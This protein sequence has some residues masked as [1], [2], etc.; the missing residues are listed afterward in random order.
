MA[1]WF[2]AIAVAAALLGG[3]SAETTNANMN[4]VAGCEAN[5]DCPSG[6]VCRANLCSNASDDASTLN[7]RFIP[8]GDSDYLPQFHEF[9]H[10]QPDEP[11][12]FL[13]HPA[14]SVRSGDDDTE[15]HP[16]GIRYDGSPLHGPQGTLIFRP[17]DAQSSL[18]IR[19]AHVDSGTFHARLNPGDYSLTFVPNDR[20][21]L[22][23]KSWAAQTFTNNT[24]LVRTL[25][26]PSEYLEVSG[27]LA[28]D[29]VL[30]GGQS[31][32]GRQVSNA[33]IYALSHNGEH[34]STIATTDE[35]GYFTLK[36]E[37]NTGRYDIF[38][39]PATSEAMVPSTELP[40]AF[41]AG[42]ADC[43]SD[44]NVTAQSCNLGQI[45]LGAYPSEPVKFSIQLT[46]SESF[47]DSF[48]LQ[49]TIVLVHGALGDG[50]FTQRY[51]VNAEG[52]A[53]LSVFPSQFSATELPN[54]TLEVIPPADSPYARTEIRIGG[55]LQTD[56]MASYA[57]GL[58]TKKSGQL[59]DAFGSPVAGAS[60][61]FRRTSEPES[62]P[63][64]NNS[65]NNDSGEPAPDSDEF[66][67]ADDR[68]TFSVTTDENGNFEVW[69]LPADYRIEAIPAQNSGQPRLHRTLS[70]ERVRAGA[71]LAFELPEARVIFGS[72]FGRTD[73]TRD[74]LN[75]LADVGVE[76]YT[77]IDGRTVVL[78]QA[79]SWSDGEFAMIIPA[80]Y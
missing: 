46:S 36:V 42:A 27:T 19:E 21:A 43:E 77:V 20:E 6:Q 53:E 60:L 12:D 28:R 50:E 39:V 26:S 63:E 62:Q 55:A 67:D 70:A 16:G 30:A 1:G 52:I 56:G 45:S 37:P 64:A 14:L 75:G 68:R 5:S 8:P 22:P 72:I 54:Y 69:L 35:N 66:V 18:F 31:L 9:V 57:L 41:F 25:L 13:L 2:A 74:D 33:R 73:T 3:C 61:E 24:I 15:E 38:V 34:S 71:P 32:P 49:G 11:T 29:V 59:L 65:D 58:K 47:V 76:A 23:K 17:V 51:P 7:F 78:G 40:D 48:S 4:T 79:L 80:E 10:V 44:E